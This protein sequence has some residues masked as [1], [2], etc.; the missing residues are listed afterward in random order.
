MWS[1]IAAN[2]ELKLLLNSS[3][4][5]LLLCPLNIIRFTLP[6][7]LCFGAVFFS[8]METDG[9]DV[10]LAVALGGQNLKGHALQV[11]LEYDPV[12]LF[13]PHH[14]QQMWL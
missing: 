7:F 1:S 14:F 2:E 13:L 9:L 10:L 12:V 8:K 6:N 3:A 4:M 5:H 11:C